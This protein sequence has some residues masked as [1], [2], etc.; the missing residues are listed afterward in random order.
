M[1][2]DNLTYMIT[3]ER[4]LFTHANAC[5]GAMYCLNLCICKLATPA[6][7]AYCVV[8]PRSAAICNLVC[9]S[10][11]R[12]AALPGT[13]AAAD[14]AAASGNAGTFVLSWA[15]APRS[16]LL[17]AISGPASQHTCKWCEHERSNVKILIRKKI[18]E[19]ASRFTH[20]GVS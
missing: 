10:I 9:S 1:Q 18:G 11:V 4:G 13:A 19:M 7:N 8:S 16:N 20:R 5:S 2:P 14:A 12:G 3:A 17:G 15:E 6:A